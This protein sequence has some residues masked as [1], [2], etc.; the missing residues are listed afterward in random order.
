MFLVLWLIA[1]LLQIVWPHH[2]YQ[3]QQS[4]NSLTGKVIAVLG[5]L[6]G[7]YVKLKFK[8][9]KKELKEVV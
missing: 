5:K 7:N 8:K 9:R 1:W 3:L 6:I 4:A 2:L